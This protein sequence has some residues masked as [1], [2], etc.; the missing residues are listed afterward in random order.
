MI[1]GYAKQLDT[2]LQH[3]K[4]IDLKNS[5]NVR[6]NINLMSRGEALANKNII[7][8]YDVFHDEMNKIVKKYDYNEMKMNIS[9][10]MPHLQNI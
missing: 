7:N 5:K 1:D 3:A 9:T 4:E 2:V 6:V 8:K 10:I